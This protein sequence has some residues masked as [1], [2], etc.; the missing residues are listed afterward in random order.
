[1]ATLRMFSYGSIFGPAC[2]VG[3]LASTLSVYLPPPLVLPH[4]IHPLSSETIGTDRYL[5]SPMHIA[6]LPSS[7][8]SSQPLWSQTKQISLQYTLQAV[9]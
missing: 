2:W 7:V 5:Y 9:Q 6:P 3:V 1:M 8:E 4:P